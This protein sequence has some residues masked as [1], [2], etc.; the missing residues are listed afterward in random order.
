MP[1]NVKS[2][3]YYETEDYVFFY[4]SCYSQWAMRNIL[5]DHVVFNCAE[6]YMMREKAKLFDDNYAFHKIMLS[7]DPADQKAW[8]KKVENFDKEKWEKVAKGIVYKANYAKFTQH[9]D[10]QQQL[11]DT[12]DKVIVEA[13]PYDII[14][15]VGLACDD[16][17]VEDPKNWQG[18][19]WLGEVIMQVREDI[20]NGKNG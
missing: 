16:P 10:W 13:S 20:K 12:G 17:R 8:G 9:E 7:E 3:S 18:T 19:N 2:K 6:Q 11:L 15:G 5:I 1:K 14:W 4:G